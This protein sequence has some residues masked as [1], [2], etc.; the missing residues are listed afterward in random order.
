MQCEIQRG[1]T[2]EFVR[3]GGERVAVVSICDGDRGISDHRAAW[4]FLGADYAA[5]VFLRPSGN[6]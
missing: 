4:I 1:S 6:D 2:R 5:R 3:G